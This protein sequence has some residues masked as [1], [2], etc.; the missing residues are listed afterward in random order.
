MMIFLFED[1]NVQKIND[2]AD[3]KQCFSYDP[4]F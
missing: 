4:H 3:Y 1:V 2:I